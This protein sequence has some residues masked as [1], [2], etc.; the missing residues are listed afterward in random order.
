MVHCDDRLKHDR[1]LTLIWLFEYRTTGTRVLI[2]HDKHTIQGVT[3]HVSNGLHGSQ[4]NLICFYSFSFPVVGSVLN[5]F[6]K[7]SKCLWSLRHIN[8]FA[9][10]MI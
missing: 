3:I 4:F 5:K 2:V 10:E 9:Y 8:M 7:T 6:H 1:L